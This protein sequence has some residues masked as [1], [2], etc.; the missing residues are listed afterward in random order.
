VKA[1]ES[2]SWDRVDHLRASREPLAIWLPTLL[3]IMVCP[4]HAPSHLPLAVCLRAARTAVLESIG[5]G[6]VHGSHEGVVRQHVRSRPPLASAFDELAVMPSPHALRKSGTFT[7][8]DFVPPP[9]F[10]R[11]VAIMSSLVPTASA[12][13]RLTR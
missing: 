3:A 6:K 9:R 2:V 13:R 4:G 7:N 5:R 1:V 12:G 10:G 8:L 11:R